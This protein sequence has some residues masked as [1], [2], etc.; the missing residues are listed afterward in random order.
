M[1]MDHNKQY[2]DEEKQE[3]NVSIPR[4]NMVYNKRS[5]VKKGDKSGLQ[6]Q[7]TQEKGLREK[8]P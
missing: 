1:E 6:E 5:R 8:R 7:R 3:E 2:D 4:R